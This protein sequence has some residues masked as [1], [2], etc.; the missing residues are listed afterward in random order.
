M[1]PHADMEEESPCEILDVSSYEQVVSVALVRRGPTFYIE[2][3]P[4]HGM[5]Y[6]A[7]LLIQFKYMYIPQT[8][9]VYM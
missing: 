3:P 7:H 2:Y 6:A 8:F 9:C 4:G 5:V 1:V